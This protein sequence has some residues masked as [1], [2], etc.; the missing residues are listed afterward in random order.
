M[1]QVASAT[2]P[3]I[4]AAPSICI[5]IML[6]KKETDTEERPLRQSVS[7]RQLPESRLTQDK[8]ETD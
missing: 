3:C 1:D 5:G 8:S 4:S 2:T 6:Q 7:K